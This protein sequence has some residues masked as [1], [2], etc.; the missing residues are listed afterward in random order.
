MRMSYS[1]L[2]YP[3]AIYSEQGSQPSTLTG[4]DSE[5]D[6]LIGTLYIAKKGKASSIL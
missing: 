2:N 3:N 5:G 4:R 1:H 6:R